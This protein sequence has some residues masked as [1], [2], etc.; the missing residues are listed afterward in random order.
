VVMRRGKYM[1][2][3]GTASPGANTRHLTLWEFCIWAYRQQRVDLMTGRTLHDVEAA[4]DGETRRGRSADGVAKMIAIGEVGADIRGGGSWGGSAECHPDAEL[5]HDHVLALPWLDA[6]GIM[7]FARTGEPPERYDVQP[8]PGP[9][10]AETRADNYQRVHIAGRL[11]NVRIAVAERFREQVPLRDDKGR[12]LYDRK[13]GE[14]I[15]AFVPG[16]LTE[17]LYCPL[18]WE[19]PLEM[20]DVTNGAYDH[21]MAG[22]E[23]LAD[24][25]VGV[26]FKNHYVIECEEAIDTH[27]KVA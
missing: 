16:P 7:Q 12:Q 14:L 19:P 26:A 20:V 5:L 15:A 27:P 17:A 21:W 3:A 23:R 6:L 2:L 22:L 11:V 24:R 25:L 18:A 10:V 4:A 13:H 8:I 1:G 9:T